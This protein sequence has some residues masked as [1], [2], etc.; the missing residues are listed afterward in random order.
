[1]YEDVRSFIRIPFFYFK[2][3]TY[4]LSLFGDFSGSSLAMFACLSK[5]LKSVDD[6]YQYYMVI[7][8]PMEIKLVS[9]TKSARLACLLLSVAGGLPLALTVCLHMCYFL[10]YVLTAGKLLGRTSK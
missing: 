7:L 3:L 2:V 5:S 9:N 1:M 10:T 6:I 8:I 4:L